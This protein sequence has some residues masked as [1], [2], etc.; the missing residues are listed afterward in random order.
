MQ[1]PLEKAKSFYHQ[2]AYKSAMRQ[3]KK[4]QG[5]AEKLHYLGL[6]S[7][8]LNQIEQAFDFF[9]QAA[10][11][12]YYPSQKYLLDHQSQKCLTI[13]QR[14]QAYLFYFA[15]LKNN[16]ADAAFRLAMLLF[17][18]QH[19]KY[20][21]K[22]LV[23]AAAWGSHEAQKKV[24]GTDRLQIINN[25]LSESFLEKLKISL[26]EADLS[27]VNL[28]DV[29]EIAFEHNAV[30]FGYNL[31]KNSLADI[32]CDYLIEI[33]TPWVKQ[34]MVIDPDSGKTKVL[35]IRTSSNTT[36]N[37]LYPSF[38]LAEVE[39][40]ICR[41]FNLCREQLEPVNV[42]QYKLNQE[43]KPHTDAVPQSDP[44]IKHFGQRTDTII[45]YLNNCAQGGETRFTKMDHQVACTRANA[46][47]FKNCDSQGRGLIESQH[48]SLP[49][50]K[51][52]KMI[53]TF[54]FRQKK[55]F[56]MR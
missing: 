23:I 1:N 18:L 13:E 38:L 22:L 15:E 24:N 32:W 41:Q 26:E 54:W 2:G 28:N 35:P 55:I 43:Y 36:F 10:A 40:Y 45:L 44:G 47:H 12:D 11:L 9:K 4:A 33:F 17:L 34:S 53:C 39:E 25:H 5:S 3:L 8:K 42:L 16:N 49:V 30:S 6:V 46:V 51:G 19:K 29:K 7:V 21:Q 48:A 56:T 20:A 31:I 50:I 14:K 37:Q 27:F 52:E